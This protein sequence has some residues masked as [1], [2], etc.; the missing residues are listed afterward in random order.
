MRG[1]VCANLLL[2]DDSISSFKKTLRLKPDFPLAHF[3][4]AQQ[5][6]ATG[7]RDQTLPSVENAIQLKRD[8]AEAYSLKARMLEQ[9][10]RPNQADWRRSLCAPST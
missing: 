6:R 4:L 2:H 3:N 8:L 1:I 5:Y 10:G 7:H 9:L